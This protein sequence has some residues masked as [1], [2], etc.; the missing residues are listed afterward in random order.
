MINFKKLKKINKPYPILIIDDF[1]EDKFLKESINQFPEY[2]NFIKYKRVM[3][4]RRYLSND[5]PEFFEYLNNNKFWLN[6]YQKIN[7][8]KF[9][10]KVLSH[11]LNDKYKLKKKLYNLKFNKNFYKKN[12]FLFN[13]IFYL[14]EFYKLVPKNKLTNIL[15]KLIKNLFYEKKKK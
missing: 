1:F 12:K 5:N 6:F 15:K 8:E 11:L 7:S 10:K 9:Y 4:N 14:K 2:S 3:G 13:F